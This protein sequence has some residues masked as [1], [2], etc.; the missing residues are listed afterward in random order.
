MVIKMKQ[1][2]LILILISLSSFVF[3][4]EK[5]TFGIVPK[6]SAEEMKDAPILGGGVY[7]SMGIPCT[8][9]TYYAQYRDEKGR[10]PKYVHIWH[11]GDWHNMALLE[12]TP[13]TGATY[14]YH[15]VPTSGKGNFY[16][17]EA[18]N[19]AGK[20]RA[21]I[22]DSPDNGPVLF[23]EKLDNNEIIILDKEGNKVWDYSTGKE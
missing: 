23:S 14:V 17:Y 10:E 11:N 18:S 15:Y 13:K 7:P 9:F 2:I 6:L 5:S 8:N 12:G 21:S 16:Y 1:I 3:A 4:E 22:I 19:G 20:A